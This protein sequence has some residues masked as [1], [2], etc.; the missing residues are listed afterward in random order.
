M[1]KYLWCN[2]S[3]M[4]QYSPRFFYLTTH[5]VGSGQVEQDLHILRTVELLETVLVHLTRRFSWGD[6]STSDRG[7]IKAI[8]VHLN[9]GFNWGDSRKS[10]RGLIE[11]FLVHLIGV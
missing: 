6:S 9:K 10:D 11:A 8:I 3:G 4:Y 7:L 2:V 1:L 5:E